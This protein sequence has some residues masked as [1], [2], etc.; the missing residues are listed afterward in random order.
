MKHGKKRLFWERGQASLEAIVAVASYIGFIALMVG[1]SSHA[2]SSS[3][4]FGE[5]LK[6]FSSEFSCVLLSDSFASNKPAEAFF[7]GDCRV[8]LS[9]FPP[10]FESGVSVE[11][12]G[13]GLGVSSPLHYGRG[14]GEWMEGTE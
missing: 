2:L 5:K 8:S 9:S 1:A 7:A 14:F 10:L 3:I 11:R 13:F 4:A 12:G 6:F